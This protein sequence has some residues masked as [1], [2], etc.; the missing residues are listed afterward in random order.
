LED[1]DAEVEIN[2]AWEMIRENNNISA[3]DSLGYFELK[4]H[5]TWFNEGCSRLLDQRKEAKL[6]WLH[7]LSEINGNNLNNVRR[8][9]SRYFR[10]KKQEYLKDKVNELAM[11]SKNK[12][13]RDLYRGIN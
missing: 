6:Q 8:R 9:A 10:N 13:I 1:L 4:K 3:K 12:N 2:S 7:N 11:N 5:K